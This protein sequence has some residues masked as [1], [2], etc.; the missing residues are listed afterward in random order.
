MLGDKGRIDMFE[1]ARRD[2]DVPLEETL[3]AL[4]EFVDQGKIGGVAL[5]EV[6]GDTIRAA[7]KIV[8]ISCVEIELS[9]FSIEPLK[10]GITQACADLGVPI[11]AYVIFFLDRTR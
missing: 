5:S 8:P 7:A 3:G 10:N 9:L 6:S 1:C 4:K 2:P 11:V